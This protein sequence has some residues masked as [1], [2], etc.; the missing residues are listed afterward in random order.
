MLIQPHDA[1]SAQPPAAGFTAVE[2]RNCVTTSSE[3]RRI[4]ANIAKLSEPLQK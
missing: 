3:A 1:G 4:S 2:A